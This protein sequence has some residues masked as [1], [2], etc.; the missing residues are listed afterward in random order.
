MIIFSSDYYLYQRE[1]VHISTI[2]FFLLGWHC[3]IYNLE[4]QSE[5]EITSK[6][7][8]SMGEYLAIP[9]IDAINKER[10]KDGKHSIPSSDDMCATA[11][12]KGLVQM[13]ILY[14]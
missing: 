2:T 9:L 10:E 5:G 12:F 3:V 8:E 4:P 1:Y 7:C 6:L 14:V 13:V 11:L